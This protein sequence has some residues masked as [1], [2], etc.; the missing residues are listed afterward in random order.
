MRAPIDGRWRSPGQLIR[1]GHVA[2]QAEL[3]RG[4]HVSRGVR[5]TDHEF[6]AACTG[7]SGGVLHCGGLRAAR[8]GYGAG[9]EADCGDGELEQ[10]AA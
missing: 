10:A 3:G 9:S 4:C 7:Y 5:L 2:D 8:C 6:A 1:D